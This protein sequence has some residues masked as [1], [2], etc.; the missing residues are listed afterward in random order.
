MNIGGYQKITLMDYPGKVAAICFVQGCQLRCPYCHNPDLVLTER[1]ITEKECKNITKDFFSYLRKRRGML[2]GIVFSGGEPLLQND[3]QE[4]LY[5]LKIEG[6][7]IK[8]DTNG[9]LPDRLESLIDNGLLDYVALDYK[10][11]SLGWSKAAGIESTMKNQY[12]KWIKSLEILDNYFIPYELRTTVVKEIHSIEDLILMGKELKNLI[13]K[14]S[15]KWFL[16]TFEK[17]HDILCDY[18]NNNTILS[19][20]SKEEMMVIKEI[21]H[22]LIP[23]VELRS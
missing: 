19:P 3:I 9:L 14:S 1:F 16:Q 11:N 5:H 12:L 7:S 13:K 23:E 4:V 20:Y 2:D 21:L 6:F 10:N 22:Q 8:L 17:N 18:Q 15:P